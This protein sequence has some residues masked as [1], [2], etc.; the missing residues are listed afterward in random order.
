MKNNKK[1]IIMPLI[2]FVFSFVLLKTFDIS[3]SA[4]DGYY[5]IRRNM[6][7]HHYIKNNLSNTASGTIL[8][9]SVDRTSSTSGEAVVVYCAEQ[10][11][12]NSSS[13]HT[14]KVLNSVSD[15]LVGSEAK[16]ELNA[17]M[18]YAYPYVTLS[19]L[20]NYLKDETIGIKASEYSSYNF[21]NLDAQES[22]TA[23]QAAIW[24]S[25]KKT[26][27]FVYGNTVS[28]ISSKQSSFKYFGKINWQKCEGY[29]AGSGKFA[30]ILTSEE[31]EWYN[32]NG[33]NTTG[34]FYKYVYNV[35][36]DG[37][38]DERINT[39]IK[40]YDS[41][42][43]KVTT[44]NANTNYSIKSFS[45]TDV[46]GS[47]TLNTVID[48]DGNDYEVTFY[49][50]NDNVLLATQNVIGNDAGNAF[51]IKNL[52]LSTTGVKVTIKSEYKT[53]SVYYYQGSGQD[54]IGVDDPSKPI[55]VNLNILNNYE[56]KGQIIVYKVA[57]N[58][59]NVDVDYESN[60]V[61][62]SKCGT[63]GCLSGAYFILYAND[64]KTI[65]REFISEKNS[66]VV[67]N[68]PNGTYYLYEQ[69]PPYG[70]T[71]Y[72]FTGSDVDSD[73]YIK[74]DITDGNTAS[75]IVNNNLVNIC[76]TKVDSQT[77]KAIDGAKFRVED[78]EG[79]TYEVFESS[80]QQD[81][82]CMN[83]QLN[84]GYY[85]LVEESAPANYV[86]TDKIF[87]FAV[88]KFN[89]DD[90]VVELEES[91]KVVLVET[92][93]DLVT[94]ENDP[95]VVISKS[96]LS[97]GACVSGAKLV[98]TD[99]DN[100]IVDEWTSSCVEGEDTHQ[101]GLQAGTYTLTETI[102]PSGYATSES[103]EFTIDENGKS[104]KSLEMKDAPIEVCILKTTAD[105]DEGLI[106]AE[107]EIYKEDG[108]F[109]QKIT[110]DIDCSA[111]T[112][113]HM[114]IGNYIIKEVKAPD[115]YKKLEEEIKITVKDTAERQIFEI[116]N[117]LE[118][119]KTDLDYSK[120]IIIIASVFMVFGSCLV[121]YYGYKKRV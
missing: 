115:G 21:D 2:V 94:I 85:Y 55:T 34:N 47:L 88:G 1:Y 57:N 49:D 121:G 39:L 111:S 117:E 60:V 13:S 110:T 101:I 36:A 73:G 106:G 72:N 107:F 91:E 70:Y 50:Y 8:V 75:V 103:I 48:S 10:G 44:I 28:S 66:I 18:P 74:I 25:I 29:N 96:D 102:A 80:S 17:W 31:K 114:P 12:N 33:C 108:S 84:S 3:Y 77:K 27:K 37:L 93:N 51:E 82:Y 14:K 95:G 89:P 52:P 87:K 71:K 104:N 100:K 58:N 68:L 41:L 99:K 23:V 15:S 105:L 42:P 59:I 90:I 54:W 64:K 6:L 9:K 40:W 86:K 20:K 5:Y 30:T 113:P 11:V 24:N 45:F 118:V 35:K 43:S 4:G 69:D 46:G 79:G 92:I 16:K 83:G 32:A 98:I 65:I 26:D 62:E 78:A 109:Y 22:M 56:A 61:D 119:P 53:K 7:S 67:G 19:E 76:F 120:V 81:K 63:N 112:I 116:E 97:N 38:S